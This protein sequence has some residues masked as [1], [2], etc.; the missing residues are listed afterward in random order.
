[1]VDFLLMHTRREVAG[2]VPFYLIR[3]CLPSTVDKYP[4]GALFK[5]PIYYEIGFKGGEHFTLNMWWPF[6]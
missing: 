2:G 4:D 5:L 6:T 3:K 1:M